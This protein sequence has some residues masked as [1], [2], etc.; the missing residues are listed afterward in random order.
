MFVV[1][2]LRVSLYCGVSYGIV[3]HLDSDCVYS[4][5]NCEREALNNNFRA[6]GDLTPCEPVLPSCQLSKKL[7]LGEQFIFSGSINFMLFL[8]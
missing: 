7:L 8:F 1:V 6:R 5:N 3:N 4:L 2:L